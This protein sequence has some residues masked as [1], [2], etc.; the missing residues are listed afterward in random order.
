M[1][2]AQQDYREVIATEESIANQIALD[3]E[4]CDDARQAADLR[5]ALVRAQRRLQQL[6]ED[7]RR[8]L[9]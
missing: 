7:A 3:L 4:G 6:Q 2:S 5:R 1:Q 9:Q 8:E